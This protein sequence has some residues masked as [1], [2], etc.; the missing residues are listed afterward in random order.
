VARRAA[1][2][3]SVWGNDGWRYDKGAFREWV[4]GAVVKGSTE[5]RQMYAFLAASF[6]DC[7]VD[8]DGFINKEEFDVL[9]EMVAALP[10]RFGFAPSWRTEY[11]T[12]AKRTS[13]RE[14]I[15]DSIDGS[16]GHKPRGKIAMGQFVSWA[17]TH[18]VGQAPKLTAT[19]GDV[20]LRNP[21]AYTVDQ[22]LVF[23]AKAVDNPQSGEAAGFYNYLLT[24][25][26]EADE[27]CGG[28][29]AFDDFNKLIDVAAKTP[30]FF[31]LAPDSQD[32]AARK[33]M[34]KAMDSTNS[35]FITFRKF[36]GFVREHIKGK[37]A[38]LE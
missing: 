26:I 9:L 1:S 36:L 22:Y 34:F 10:R 17:Q 31:Q 11:G 12:K 38:D 3:T 5:E 29:I 13:A 28:K 30:R 21:G 25:F 4:K 15:F 19:D 16:D 37:L 27:G 32:E 24:S 18:V 23:L 14:A 33:A 20:A 8:K 35:G 7:D 2:T 6:G